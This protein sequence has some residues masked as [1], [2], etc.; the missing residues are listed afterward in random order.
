MRIAY[1]EPSWNV[2]PTPSRRAIWSMMPDESRLFSAYELSLPLLSLSIM[3][4]RKS[5][6][7]LTTVTP[8]CTT[9]LGR[10]GVASDTL[11]CVCTWAMSPFVPGSNVS[12]TDE[13][14][15]ALELELKYIR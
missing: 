2:L 5:G 1:S 11:F 14:P 3:N 8:C 6:L 4:I 13:P 15:F 12:V 10:R 9:S 7:D